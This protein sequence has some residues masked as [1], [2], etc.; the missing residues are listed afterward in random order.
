MKRGL[1]LFG[2]AGISDARSIPQQLAQSSVP[3]EYRKDVLD[4]LEQTVHNL[5]RQLT[6]TVAQQRADLLALDHSHNVAR[7][8][9]QE[10]LQSAEAARNAHLESVHSTQLADATRRL[11]SRA[12]AVHRALAKL[13]AV[14]VRC[15][16]SDGLKLNIR[17]LDLSRYRNDY[18]GNTDL[19]MLWNRRTRR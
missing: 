13:S 7:V 12:E 9:Y 4:T 2:R 16:H 19:Y 14:S 17:T 5:Q 6:Q 1:F 11:T 18:Y 3:Q 10:G 8:A 15:Y